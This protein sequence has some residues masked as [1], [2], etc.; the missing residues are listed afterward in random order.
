MVT[1]SCA[2]LW[3]GKVNGRPWPYLNPGLICL[4]DGLLVYTL[5]DS[6]F[7]N[8]FLSHLS[9]VNIFTN[10]LFLE[11]THCNKRSRICFCW[12][13]FLT[14]FLQFGKQPLFFVVVVNIEETKKIFKFLALFRKERW[15][16]CLTQVPILPERLGECLFT[17]LS[18]NTKT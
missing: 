4:P 2:K 15:R 13:V 9:H 7:S 3:P 5:T 16:P 8:I 18:L 17:L 12:Q 14:V 6:Q 10:E 1:W 11:R